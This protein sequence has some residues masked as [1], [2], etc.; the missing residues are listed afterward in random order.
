MK[1]P[2]ILGR[3]LLAGALFMVMRWGLGLPESQAIGLGILCVIG[4]LWVTEALH[5]SVTALLVPVLA[6]FT[7]VFTMPEAVRAFA[8]PIIFLFLGGF[9]LAA[10]LHQQGLDKRIACKILGLAKG[11]LS[12]AL[13]YLFLVT[14]FLSMW[15]SNTATTAMMLPLTL[16]VLKT[17]DAHQYKSTYLY[18]LL[19]IAFAANIGGIGTLVGSPP[20]AIAAAAVGL[21]FASWMQYGIPLVFILLP[22]MTLV[23]Y[24]ALKPNLQHQ[25][26]ISAIA[27]PQGAWTIKDAWVMGVFIV[28]VILWIFGSVFAPWMGINQGWDAWVALSALILLHAGGVLSWRTLNEQTDWSVL[29]LFGGGITLSRLLETTGTSVFMAEH[30]SQSLQAAPVFVFLLLV[31]VFVMALTEVASNTASAALMVPI[32]VSIAQAQGYASEVMAVLIAVAASCAFLL[33]VATPP[34]AI[35]YGSGFVPQRDMLRVGS[36]LTLVVLPWLVVLAWLLI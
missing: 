19:G 11:R 27:A 33:P 22:V 5:V 18:A 36:W 14:A 2:E 12:Y 4:V 31:T 7:G 20:N 34:N 1:M 24:W 23:L 8:D 29:L 30:L 17:L 25:Q 16:G 32:F 28:T 26:I 3:L 15:I 35:V 13:L 6:V 9:A 21:D 10:A